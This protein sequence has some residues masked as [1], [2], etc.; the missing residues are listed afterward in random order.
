MKIVAVVLAA[1]FIAGPAAV[2][3]A[4]TERTREEELITETMRA[5]PVEKD[6]IGER[7]EEEIKDEDDVSMDA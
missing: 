3:S 5:D 4:G 7:V 6:A 1:C 2:V